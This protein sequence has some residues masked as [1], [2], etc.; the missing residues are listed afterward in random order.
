MASVGNLVANFLANT[1]G[2]TKPVADMRKQTAS[3]A[4]DVKSNIGK[5]SGAFAPLM[6]IVA[7]IAGAFAFKHVVDSAREAA[8][9]AKKFQA[10]VD[11][12][13]GAAGITTKEM[14]DFAGQLQKTTNFEDDATTAAAAMLATFTNIRGDVFKDAVKGAMDMAT[15]METDL[16]S[17]IMLIGKA[18]NDPV[19]GMAKLA[20]SG[21]QLSEEQKKQV[22]T[23]Q[24]QGDLVGAQR[25]ILDA[26]QSKFG[27]AAEAMASPFKQVQNIIGDIS[28]NIGFALLPVLKE[29]VSVVTDWATPIQNATEQF[30]AFGEE[31]AMTFRNFNSIFELAGV[32]MELA[33]IDAVPG[34]QGVF[35]EL[36]AD[37]IAI[38]EGAKAGFGAFADNVMG[39]FKEIGNVFQALIAGMEAGWQ[40]VKS[41][42][43][44][45][46]ASSFADA[47]MSTLASQADTAEAKNPFSE[48]GAAFD[49]TRRDA[50]AGFAEPGGGLADQLRERRDKLLGDIGQVEGDRDQKKRDAERKGGKIAPELPGAKAGSEIKAVEAVQF[51]SKEA[52][53]NIFSAMR[54]KGDTTQEQILAAAERNADASEEAVGFLGDMALGI[55]GLGEI[56]FGVGGV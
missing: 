13:G 20:R 7:P 31:V 1:Q 51:N 56:E 41:G 52:L 3:F 34:M 19:N 39:G 43:F 30:K 45:D 26:M 21:V 11:A 29:V 47:F 27:G 35:Q 8:A 16:P 22:A 14:Q 48:F 24:K 2:F 23:L 46:A 25:V 15:V 6:S 36:G 37:I 32:N 28:E 33:I 9:A 4:A 18:L 5:I 54:S 38:W 12:T 42:N 50:L 10:V 55:Q 40:K 53:S 44:K 49:R 17:A